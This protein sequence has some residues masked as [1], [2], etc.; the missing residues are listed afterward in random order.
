MEYLPD[1][2]FLLIDSNRGIYIP[3]EFARIWG[4]FS[5]MLEQQK[6]VLLSGP[7]NNDYWDVWS[8]IVDNVVFEFDGE[9]CVLWECGDLFAVPVN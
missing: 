6:K 2:A 9:K 8:E 7:D 4:N 3:R 1:N 5:N